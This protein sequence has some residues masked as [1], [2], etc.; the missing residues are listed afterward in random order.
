M[1]RIIRVTYNPAVEADG[2]TLQRHRDYLTNTDTLEQAIEGVRA[3]MQ[4][5]I[6]TLGGEIIT[7]EQFT[8]IQ[9]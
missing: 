3:E 6:D 1:Q 5:L 8:D 7:I 4:K 9:I 2:I